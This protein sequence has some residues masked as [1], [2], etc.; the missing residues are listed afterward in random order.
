LAGFPDLAFR[1]AVITGDA[2]VFELSHSFYVCLVRSMAS[3][4]SSNGEKLGQIRRMGSLGLM[5]SIAIVAA[6]GSFPAGSAQAQTLR[7]AK[8]PPVTYTEN[9]RIVHVL[10][11]LGFGARPEDIAL[12]KRIGLKV[13]ID[14]QLNPETIDDSAVDQKLQSF[15]EL[16]MSDADIESKYKDF[17]TLDQ[18]GNK[19]R[20]RLRKMEAMKLA[21]NTPMTSVDQSTMQTASTASVTSVT[22]STASTTL[23]SQTAA[24]KAEVKAIRQGVQEMIASDPELAK[25]V[26]DQ[27]RRL[28]EAANPIGLLHEEFTAS[29]I[30]RAVESKRQLQEV[31]VDF[32]TNHFNIDIRKAPCGI[33]KVIDDR[34]VIR[35]HI[36]GKFRDLLEASAK[37]PAMLVY[38]DNFQSVSENLP[39]PNN[40][41]RFGRFAALNQAAN[42][43]QLQ[44]QVVK[45]KPRRKLGLNENYAREVMEL[46]T[47]GVT[48]GYTQQDVREV[49]RCFTGWSIAS[50][51]GLR[52]RIN[53]YGEAGVFQ[54]YPRVHDEGE[55]VVLGH[56]IPADGGQRDGE[57]VLNLLAEDPATRKHISYEL[58]QCLV[59]DEPPSSLVNKCIETWQNTDGDLREVVRTIVTSPEFFSSVA[60]RKKIKSPFEYAVSSVRALDGTLD[61]TAMISHRQIAREANSLIRPPQGGGFIDVNTNSMIGEIA[62]M[63]EPLFQYLAPTGFP[64]DSRKW[65]SSGALISRLNF[66]LALT[67]GK[68]KDVQLADPAEDSTASMDPTA[69]IDKM[70][71]QILHGEISPSTRA[72]LLSEAKADSGSGSSSSMTPATVEALLLGSP[73]F[74]RR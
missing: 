14:Q 49:A 68:I 43:N 51:D 11:R 45:R 29:K 10:N 70:S 48:G 31:L 55:K 12:V 16:Q 15:T 66:S 30:I 25:E 59:C 69:L 20:Q 27:R 67:Q 44:T 72:T 42:S 28:V 39:T 58:C 7:T 54:F 40:S 4:K 22:P 2:I 64:E 46:H 23:P 17:I 41:R 33:L 37:S 52:P 47:L 50:P 8:A 26:Q 9:D 53:R 61:P 5:A 60:M 32:W 38:L 3:S 6:Q 62:T 71:K 1:T 56:H 63:G 57:I 36:F 74:Q 24:P 19:L 21:E 34:D 73:E 35:P 65:V 18:D 13:Y